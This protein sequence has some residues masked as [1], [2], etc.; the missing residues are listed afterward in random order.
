MMEQWQRKKEA[1]QA[2]MAKAYMDKQDEAI[3]KYMTEHPDSDLGGL[4]PPEPKARQSFKL[5]KHKTSSKKVKAKV[6]PVVAGKAVKAGEKED[7]SL[8][9]SKK[10]TKSAES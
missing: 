10:D 8:D 5:S 2:A 6:I 7:A 3:A 9:S 4:Q 1:K